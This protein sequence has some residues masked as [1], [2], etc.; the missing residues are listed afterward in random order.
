MNARKIILIG[1]ITLLT[2][3]STFAQVSVGVRAGANVSK[4]A[5]T[6]DPFKFGFQVGVVVDIPLV[7][8]KLFLQTGL[9]CIN[10]I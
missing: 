2:I 10:K 9:Y 6:S 3:C 7:K 4:F 8:Q 1:V 5:S